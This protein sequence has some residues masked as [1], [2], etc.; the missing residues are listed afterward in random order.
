MRITLANKLFDYMGASLAVLAADLPPMERIVAETGAGLL[1]PVGSTEALA[2]QL[3]GL[4]REPDR[5]RRLGERG[6]EAVVT[7][8][9]WGRDEAVWLRIV[10]GAAEPPRPLRR[11]GDRTALLVPPAKA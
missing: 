9:N 11:R 4:L 2:A 3:V 10:G 8:Y 5:C 7:K 6:R 1:Y